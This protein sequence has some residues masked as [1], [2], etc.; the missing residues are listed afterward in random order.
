MVSPD[1][2]LIA[3]LGYDDRGKGY[4][5]ADLYVMNLDG[6][7]A[8]ADRARPRPRHRASSTGPRTAARSIV[9]YEEDGSVTVSRDRPRRPVTPIADGLGGAGLDRPYTGGELQRRAQRRDRLHH[10]QRRRARPT[11]RSPSGGKPRQLTRLNDRPVAAKSLGAAAQARRSPRP[12]APSRRL[13][14]HSRRA[15]SRRHSAYPLILEIHGGPY[16]AYGPHFSTDDQLYAAAG[17]AVLYTN[18]RGSTGYGQAFAD[19]ID[20]AYPGNDYDDLMAAVDAAI[21]SGIAD[22]DNLFVTGGSG[23][24]V[25]TAWIVGKTDRFRAAAAQKPVI[26]WT[27]LAL[28]TDG[29]SFFGRYWS[30]ACRGRIPRAIGHT[31]R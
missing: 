14:D 17:Y 20:K 23:G 8:R 29:A 25:L 27:S 18:P 1:G 6:S 30:A 10:R 28:T 2:R 15:I 13:D 31:R 22:P 19:R 12:T 3:Y 7:G 4:E 9:T 26:N 11:S 16:A 24:G 5:Q 21:A